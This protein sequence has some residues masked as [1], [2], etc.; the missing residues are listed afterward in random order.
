MIQLL[1]TWVSVKD[2]LNHQMPMSLDFA[3]TKTKNR[4][5]EKTAKKKSHGLAVRYQRT[6][7]PWL[8]NIYITDWMVHLR[9]PQRK[10]TQ[11]SRLGY[12]CIALKV[13]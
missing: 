1:V 8:F 9:S 5:A 3:N 4:S 10:Q 6:A 12:H 13:K 2:R 11:Q 7:N